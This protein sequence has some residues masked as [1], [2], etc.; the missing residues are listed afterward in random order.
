MGGEKSFSNLQLAKKII[1]ILKIKIKIYEVKQSKNKIK[2][3]K[4][5]PNL[6]KIKLLT[7]WKSKIKLNEGIKKFFNV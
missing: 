4:N 6:N 1:K 3:N 2:I 7:N 5:S